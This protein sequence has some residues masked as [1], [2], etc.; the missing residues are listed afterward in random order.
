MGD[1]TPCH[2]R[3]RAPRR[4]RAAHLGAEFLQ[5]GL[6]V[7]NPPVTLAEPGED[8]DSVTTPRVSSPLPLQPPSPPHRA[9]TSAALSLATSL[10]CWRWVNC[11][12]ALSSSFT[13]SSSSACAFC[14]CSMLWE[15]DVSPGTRPHCPYPVPG[16]TCPQ[17]VPF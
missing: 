1:T 16:G 2:P 12:F 15:R 14:S 13:V 9:S 10:L 3:T 8:R 6:G 4:P 7:E 11:F 5:A 17:P